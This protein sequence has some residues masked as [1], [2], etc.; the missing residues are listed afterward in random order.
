MKHVLGIYSNCSSGHT[1]VGS[2]MK[3][4]G[5]ETYYYVTRADV[6]EFMLQPLNQHNIPSG[7]VISLNKKEFLTNYTPE[8]GYYEKK[9][10]P[11]LKS[12]QT[13]IQKGENYYKDG[14]LDEA[15]KEFA[16]A[17]TLDA[18]SPKA[19]LGMGAV[20][21]S[22]GNVKKL[23]KII[24]I[25][26]NNDEVFL[27]EQRQQFNTFAISLRKQSLYEDAIRFYIKAIEI[28]SSDENLHFN[29]ARVYFEKGDTTEA[30]LHIEKALEIDPSL[31]WAHK[32]KSY[33][34]KRK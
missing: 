4:G 15:E 7:V 1:G 31:E 33:I 5:H 28:N 12:L 27:E 3:R 8:P 6:D 30:L 34:M 29:L 23:E 19:N 24:D 18:K 2:T 13:K 17:L 32:F 10:L 9:A 14:E 21:S 16:K 11:A 25:L 20:Q 26:L 22:K